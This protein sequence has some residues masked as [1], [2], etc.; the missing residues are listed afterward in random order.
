M[1]WVFRGQVPPFNF[2]LSDRRLVLEFA[3]QI[4]KHVLPW[5]MVRPTSSFII[6]TR[7]R[8]LRI[9]VCQRMATLVK[10]L[11]LQ[12]ESLKTLLFLTD[13][14]LF[15]FHIWH[16][17]SSVGIATRYRLDGPGMKS[18]LERDFSHSSWPALRPTQ[19]PNSEYL[20]IP[21]GKATRL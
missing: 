13:P 11:L 8:I 4:S 6:A 12:P 7:Y 16:I 14:T 9:S 5:N 21:G 18:R 3:H 20:V 19:S 15:N 17:G 2:G 1:K 10:Y